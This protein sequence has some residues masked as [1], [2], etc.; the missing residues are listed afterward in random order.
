[1][2]N[3]A[4]FKFHW[5]GLTLFV[6]WIGLGLWAVQSSRLVSAKDLIQNRLADSSGLAAGCIKDGSWR[7]ANGTERPDIAQ[8]VQ[9]VLQARSLE[10]FVS[11]REYGEVDGCGNFHMSSMDFDLDFPNSTSAEA[12]IQQVGAIKNTLSAMDIPRLGNVR[13]TVAG[14]LISRPEIKREFAVD[15]PVHVAPGRSVAQSTPM[16]VSKALVIIYNP[17]MTNGQH[18][19]DRYAYN[20]PAQIT[21]Q[22]QGFFA[23]VSSGKIQYVVADTIELNEFTLYQDGYRYSPAEYEAVQARQTQSHPGEYDYN[24]LVND[25][26]FDICGK[27]NRHEID[28]VWLYSM[29]FSAGFAESTLVGPDAYFYNSSPVPGPWT[30]DRLVPIMGFNYERGVSEAT[31]DFGHRTEFTLDHVY[32]YHATNQVT[33]DWDR[34][35]EVASFYPSFSYS[36]CGVVHYPPNGQ[37]DYDWSEVTPAQTLCDDFYNYPDLSMAG[38]TLTTVDCT[39]WGCNSLGYFDYWYSH[40]PDKPGCGP[41]GK[42][43]DWW[44]YFIVPDLANSPA[45][46]CNLVDPAR[47]APLLFNK[48]APANGYIQ[49]ARQVTFSWQ[50]SANAA[51][52]EVCYADSAGGPCHNGW[53]NV[54]NQLTATF[55]GLADNWTYY[56]QVRAINTQADT[57][58]NAG[59]WSFKVQNLPPAAFN[60]AGPQPGSVEQNYQVALSWESSLQA[61]SY[62]YC[63]DTSNNDVCNTGWTSTGNQSTAI[64]P[65]RLAY[66]TTYYWQVQ[67]INE[68]GTAE[69][70]DGWRSFHTLLAPQAGFTKLTP[71][72]YSSKLQNSLLLSWSSL[73]GA[74]AYE[75]CIANTSERI[76]QA[77][78][79]NTGMSTMARVSGLAFNSDFFWQVRAIT[80]VGS[81]EANAN[82]WYSWYQF[83]TRRAPAAAFIKL[84]PVYGAPNQSLSVTAQWEKGGRVEYYQ[85]CLDTTNDNQCSGNW[86]YNGPNPQVT[87]YSLAYSTTYYWQVRALFGGSA[88]P[89][90]ADTGAWG[91]FTTLSPPGCP[92]IT[93]WRGE[94]WDNQTLSGAAKLCR[95]DQTIN[96]DWWSS[97]PD[98]SLSQGSYSARW[99]RIL[100]FSGKPYLFHISH[101]DGARMYID[102]ALKLDA[103]GSCCQTDNAEVLMSPGSHEIKLEMVQRGGA[104]NMVFWYEPVTIDGWRAEFYNNPSLAGTPVLIRDDPQLD[105]EWYGGSPDPLVL[106]EQFSARWTRQFYFTAG[107]YTFHIFHDDGA[108]L[109]IDGDKVFE[110]WCAGCRQTDDIMRSLTQGPHTLQLEMVEY[111]GWSS[112]RLTWEPGAF[113]KSGPRDGKNGEKYNP[114]LSWAGSPGVSGYEFCYDMLPGADCDTDWIPV[115]AGTSV[116]LSGLNPS[117]T[118]YWQVRASNA[119]GTTY[120]DSG[121]WW[122]FTTS[123]GSQIFLPV[124]KR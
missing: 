13:F 93:G 123:A 120:A 109:F 121:A 56:W 107:A 60:K 40:F 85:Y 69:A 103:W 79:T 91:S 32:G 115:A 83:N 50:S 49:V 71:A 66:N 110:D 76:C 47:P 108:R 44:R 22:L 81:V 46:A 63:Y 27:V 26:R 45:E 100:D 84:S 96:F 86:I 70:A 97:P 11:A 90:E 2:S 119:G 39:T 3:K 36:G 15:L 5:S 59:W 65:D 124:V 8:Q 35:S 48:S 57:Q 101:D 24:Q 38:S 111:S 78:W 28:E 89:V 74:T 4:R 54:G 105:F 14:R 98:P 99:T 95:A 43:T 92:T 18:L 42:T 80:P 106:P 77:G 68:T 10:V 67:A 12:A 112:A 94:Y 29:P 61:N 21:G 64:I 37:A 55:Q 53:H 20:S 87:I 25:A 41:D 19:I 52:Y 33:N 17:I 118:Y 122:S 114:T 23:S 82:D 16:V 58:A 116:T 1:M 73:S 104:A 75:Y 31:E 30:C 62:R 6:F 88:Q 7:W 34:F 72:D 102:G 51:S 117:T 9:A 113:N